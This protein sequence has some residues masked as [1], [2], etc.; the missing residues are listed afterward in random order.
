MNAV[1]NVYW[2]VRHQVH[3]RLFPV[4]HR[5]C[6]C[7]GTGK[8]PRKPWESSAAGSREDEGHAGDCY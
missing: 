2:W 6:T 4:V 3:Y 1:R 8:L 5:N 7:H